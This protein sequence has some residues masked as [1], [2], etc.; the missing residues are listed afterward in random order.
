MT[1]NRD[2]AT[3]ATLTKIPLLSRIPG[4]GCVVCDLNIY[5]STYW[6]TYFCQSTYS[7]L[8][9]IS[10]LMKKKKTKGRVKGTGWLSDF[11]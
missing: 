11:S 9:L 6:A 4:L 10:N 5:L 3:T 1:S 2:L 7:W 8:Y